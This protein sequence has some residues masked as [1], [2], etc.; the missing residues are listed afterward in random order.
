ML[1]ISLSQPV[2][3]PNHSR[4][5]GKCMQLHCLQATTNLHTFTLWALS[6][7]WS[8]STPGLIIILQ[9]ILQSWVQHRDSTRPY[10]NST[11]CT[12]IYQPKILVS[13]DL[14][15]RTSP[16]YLP[17]HASSY[18]RTWYG[19]GGPRGCCCPCSSP[20]KASSAS[21]EVAGLP[22]QL[23]QRLPMTRYGSAKYLVISITIM[24][25]LGTVYDIYGPKV[26]SCQFCLHSQKAWL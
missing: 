19:G 24:H 17:W 16:C 23:L 18:D 25:T 14:L 6:S 1:W 12:W 21:S 26:T 15:H 2:C 9:I 7:L 4:A 13:F 5:F 22:I 10:E 3:S 20:S 11:S 8:P